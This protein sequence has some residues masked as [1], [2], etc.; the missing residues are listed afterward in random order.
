MKRECTIKIQRAARSFLIR[1]VR[2]RK[3]NSKSEA[4]EK[5]KKLQ[6]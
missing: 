1:K 6:V 2:E 5:N 4:A 3:S